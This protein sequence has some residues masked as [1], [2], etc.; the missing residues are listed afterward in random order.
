MSGATRVAGDYTVAWDGTG[1]DGELVPQGDYVLFVE[2]AR[3]HGPY[4]ITSQQ[5]AVG[6]EAFIVALPDDGELANLSAT[7][8]V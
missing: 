3:E 5:V 4:E 7:F 2:A 6:T 8:V 1:L